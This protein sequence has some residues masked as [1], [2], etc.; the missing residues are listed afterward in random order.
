M[1]KLN[2]LEECPFCGFLPFVVEGIEA[3]TQKPQA[4]CGTIFCDNS[5]C[6][7]NPSVDYY[8]GFE[9]GKRVWNKR[10]GNV[11]IIDDKPNWPVTT[12]KLTQESIDKMPPC[13]NAA[14]DKWE[15]ENLRPQDRGRPRYISCPCPRCNPI[16]M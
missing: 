13:A 8:N 6:G 5:A 4:E 1:I 12:F 3:G 7:V 16:S 15:A 2:D 9:Q 11:M 14:M 10:Y